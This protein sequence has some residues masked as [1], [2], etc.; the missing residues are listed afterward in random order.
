MLTSREYWNRRSVLYDTKIGQIYHECYQ[1]TIHMSERYLKPTASVLDVGCG[2]GIIT[3]ELARQVDHIHAIDVS[4]DMLAITNDKLK[5]R[6]INNVTLDQMNI[7]D[8]SLKDG[9]F[10]IIFAFN[11]LNYLSDRED[12][13]MRMFN[14]LKPGGYLL[15]ATDLLGENMS[16]QSLM[17][18]Y[19]YKRGESST[20]L[21][22]TKKTILQLIA[23]Q[24]FKILEY[25]NLY[26]TPPNLFVAAKKPL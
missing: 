2:T 19:S 5:R 13:V 22:D 1:R 20:I 25:E 8:S 4:E 23:G 21:F 16:R 17:K 14:L 26:R 7:F 24:G 12:C 11:V 3:V 15:T 9:S 6:G 10:D 18:W